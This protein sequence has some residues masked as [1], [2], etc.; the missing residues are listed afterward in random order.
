MTNKNI[1]PEEILNSTVESHIG[2]HS[3]KTSLFFLITFT[4][5]VIAFIALP[6]ISIDI[7][8]TSRGTI[9]PQEKK[10]NI[11]APVSGRI[12]YFNVEENQ[13]IK[14]GDTLLIIE[15]NVL[16]ERENLNSIQSSENA[17][18]L[19]DLSNLINKNYA[20]ITSDHYKRELLKH[21]QELYNLDVIIKNTQ[22]DF[23]RTEQ[24]YK[25]RCRS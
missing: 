5:V 22:N 10:L 8:T 17:S 24:L 18:Y 12:S 13:K 4:A 11:Y 23:N 14:K 3:K 2:K 15:H 9:I 25:K 6:F 21:Q 7:Y 20:N 19:N 1:F 16:K